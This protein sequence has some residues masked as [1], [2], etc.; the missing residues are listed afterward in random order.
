VAT[1]A[2]TPVPATAINTAAD[3]LKRIRA[4]TP[5][6][7]R[8]LGQMGYKTFAS[9]ANWQRADV[10]RVN[11]SLGFRDRVEHENW[12]EQAQI[13]SKGGTTA[14]AQDYA[15]GGLTTVMPTPAV[16]PKAPQAAPQPAP[17]PPAPAA[18]PAAVIQPVPVVAP[19]PVATPPPAAAPAEPPPAAA[20]PAETPSAAAAAAAAVSAAVAAA[21]RPAT[22]EAPK[23]PT[24][25]PAPTAPPPAASAAV[26]PSAAPT[27][28]QVADRAAFAAAQPA[29][30]PPVASTVP[31][32]AASTAEPR[33]VA[34]MPATA[35][36]VA[37]IAPA[38]PIASAAPVP[39]PATLSSMSSGDDLTR[40]RT[41]NPDLAKTLNMQ[42]VTRFGQIAGWSRQDVEKFDRLLGAPGRIDRESWI[43]QARLLGGAAMEPARSAPMPPPAS[44]VPP[45]AQAPSQH[46]VTTQQPAPTRVV[47]PPAPAAPQPTITQGVVAAGTAAATAVAPG[48]RTADLSSLV[49]VRSPH[50][51]DQGLAVPGGGTRVLKSSQADDLK[52]IR[53]IGVLIEK[54]LNQ[55]GVTSYDQIANWT[56]AD[57]DKFNSQL[58]FKGRIERE[59]WVEQAR[60]LSSGGQT[61]FSRRLDRGS[62]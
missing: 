13:L 4:I 48:P 7:E 56:S 57:I 35:A 36:P 39:P 34:A 14:Y 17:V 25:A 6:I 44:T 29:A 58:E 28:P 45:P 43:D 22:T 18:Q 41:I 8:S 50:L 10:E 12:I 2:P 23:A 38:A 42:G 9:I 5:E 19:T 15:R 30:K 16:A 20:K 53:G 26:A 40:I 60:I 54:R 24:P 59:S 27:P 47:E 51:R 55:L 31:P 49:S 11:S 61:E 33:A 62:S 32:P 1:A 37:P 3:D 21:T 46:T 52:R